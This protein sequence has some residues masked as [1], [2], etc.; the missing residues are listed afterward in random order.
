MVYYFIY[1]LGTLIANDSYF[2][3]SK[4][5]TDK[6]HETPNINCDDND[7]SIPLESGARFRDDTKEIY[8]LKNQ[9]IAVIIQANCNIRLVTLY[10]AKIQNRESILLIIL[11]F[12]IRILRNIKFQVFRK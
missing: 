5:N 11:Y 8:I 12:H 2:D 9:I 10:G 4:D 6:H 3:S 1:T 7:T